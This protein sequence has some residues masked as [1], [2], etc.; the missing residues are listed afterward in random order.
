MKRTGIVF[1]ALAAGALLS[2]S[3]SIRA[4]AATDDKPKAET[5][6]E[7]ITPVK[8]A[9]VWAEFDGDKK[10]K[11]LPYILT[12]NAGSNREY[13]LSKIR[14]GTKV[15]IHTGKDG[16]LQYID[17]GTN[18]D[19]RVSKVDDGSYR[20]ELVVERS[21]VESE[22]NPGAGDFKE[23][24]IRQFRTETVISLRD[25]QTT[26]CTVATD[27]VSGRVSK[28]EVSLSVLK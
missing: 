20:L 23:P 27:P 9:V 17:V 24:I 28:I 1:L 12:V 25:G 16:A 6:A 26:E 14:V 2:S 11:S 15:P 18:I 7:K 5:H 22:V 8:V 4:Q 10:V 19:C 21:W 13:Q 3:P